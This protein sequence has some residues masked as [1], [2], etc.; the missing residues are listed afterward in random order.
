MSISL[1][2]VVPEKP[3][4]KRIAKVIKPKKTRMAKIKTKRYVSPEANPN[5][6]EKTKRIS[7]TL[8]SDKA[9]ESW[10]NKQYKEKIKTLLTNGAY[11]LDEIAL[12]CGIARTL[13]LFMS[14]EQKFVK[15]LLIDFKAKKI[16]H[17]GKNYYYIKVK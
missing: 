12:D 5:L 1:K 6:E 4:T 7:H 3:R 2:D 9:Y 13:A 14:L 16:E 10:F 15:R 17:K 8:P 11:S